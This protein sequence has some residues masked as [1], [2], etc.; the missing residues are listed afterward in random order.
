MRA[1]SASRSGLVLTRL[2]VPRV[3]QRLVDRER[4]YRKL[5]MSL[6]RRLTMV[7]APAGY[8][9]SAA[10]SGWLAA[11]RVP[12]AWASLAADDTPDVFWR[13]IYAACG[14]ACDAIAG[15]SPAAGAAHA[16]APLINALVGAAD[17]ICIVL[18]DF[19]FVTNTEILLELAYLIDYLPSTAHLMLI[20]RREPSLSL[21]R[22][23]SG[24]EL[25]ADRRRG[26]AVQIS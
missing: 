22:T 12:A 4:I 20:C 19:R 24:R 13:Y 23:R 21:G 9:K 14:S 25:A 26:F 8:G 6:N 11:R 10:V 2:G 16:S 1:D 18:D 7:T 3:G 15:V 5:D 17:P